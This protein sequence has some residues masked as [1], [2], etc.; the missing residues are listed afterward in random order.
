MKNL[1]LLAWK[2]MFPISKQKALNIEIQ[3]QKKEAVSKL[4]FSKYVEDV[5]NADINLYNNPK[6]GIDSGSRIGCTEIDADII[7][8]TLAV[9]LS[10]QWRLFKVIGLVPAEN[11]AMFSCSLDL[12]EIAR[13]EV[14]NT[15]YH[16]YRLAIN[17][18]NN[19]Q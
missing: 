14:D 8:Q 10:D 9:P 13:I 12:V 5:S 2:R 17:E 1:I 19:L 4:W 18:E 6:L 16:E 3:R 7:G 11:L 15:N